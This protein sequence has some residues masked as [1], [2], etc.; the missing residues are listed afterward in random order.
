MTLQLNNTPCSFTGT[1]TRQDGTTLTGQFIGIVTGTFLNT[2]PISFSVNVISDA[3]KKKID[4]FVKAGYDNPQLLDRVRREEKIDVS[5]LKSIGYDHRNI[6][7]IIE[8]LSTGDIHSLLWE[9]Y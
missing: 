5:F 9:K 2:I 6:R 1:L 8:F 3:A 4:L 7:N